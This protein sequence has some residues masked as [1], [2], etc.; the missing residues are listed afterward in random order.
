MKRKTTEHH[1]AV[2]A[3]R[4]EEASEKKQKVDGKKSTV[5][6]AIGSA[7]RACVWSAVQAGYQ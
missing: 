7:G 5:I 2:D 6:K 3:E 4:S 1:A